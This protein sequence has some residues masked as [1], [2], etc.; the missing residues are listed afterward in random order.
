MDTRPKLRFLPILLGLSV[1]FQLQAQ[2]QDSTEAPQREDA[3]RIFIDCSR[4]DMNYI[5]EE[6]PYVNYVRDVKEAQVYILE[7]SETTG[8]GGRK[9][10]YAFVGQGEFLGR[11]DTLVYSSRPDDTR[12]YERIWRTQM[13]KMGLMPYVASSPLFKEVNIYPSE[14]VEEQVVEGRWNNWVFELDAEPNFEGEETLKELSLRSSV[15]ATKITHDWKLELEFDH[16]YTRTKYT[17]DDTLY[18]NY[19]SY[20]GLDVLVVKSLG[21][22]WSAGMRSQ[23]LSSSYNNI[24][25]SLE[26]MPS[27]E[28]N[29]FPYSKSTNKQLRIL[30][31]IGSSYRM[32]S[33]TTIYNQIE[34]LL[35]QQS[36]QVAYEVREKWGSINVSLEGSNFFHDFSKNRLELGGFI[37]I[38]VLKGLS[39]RLRGGVARINDQLSLV[40]GEASEAEILLQLQ[41][42]A[43]G[44]NVE[45]EIGITYTFGSIYNNIVNP[46]FGNGRRFF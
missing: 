21:E 40:R 11:N 39:V 5:R 18:T 7:T 1:L 33:D 41:E 36:L 4:C 22:H 46:R 37:S 9:Y 42:L 17:Y 19:K 45:G 31:G 15:S 13:L 29:I 8:S 23:L 28:Y 14:N 3:V 25:F 20:R 35:W 2:E 30:Y 6:I 32:Y 43:T 16:R 24:S 34:E 38:R 27:L 26:I 12:D 44:Y 10:T